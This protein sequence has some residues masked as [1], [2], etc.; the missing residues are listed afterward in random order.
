MH[1]LYCMCHVSICCL[2]N[3]GIVEPLA[4]SE[5]VIHKEFFDIINRNF[6]ADILLVVLVFYPKSI[7]IPLRKYLYPFAGN[8]KTS[9]KC[10]RFGHSTAVTTF[11]SPG[12]KQG[13]RNIK[14]GTS[15]HFPHGRITRVCEVHIFLFSNLSNPLQCFWDHQ[16]MIYSDNKLTNQ[17]SCCHIKPAQTISAN[18][19]LLLAHFSYPWILNRGL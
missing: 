16:D 17:G 13:L 3:G 8:I 2:S 10:S 1:L 14:T 19:D 18:R 5:H 11:I 4:S 7:F 9:T 12:W 15:Y 6:G